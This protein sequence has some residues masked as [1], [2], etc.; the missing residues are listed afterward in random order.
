[1]KIARF[2]FDKLLIGD[3][4]FTEHHFNALVKYNDKNNG[5]FFKVGNKKIIF[6]N[7][8]GLLQVG[9]LT[10]EIL[11]KADKNTEDTTG[12]W[13]DALVKMLNICRYIRLKSISDANLRLRSA[14]LF[15]LYIESFL[16][17]FENIMHQGLQKKYRTIEENSHIFKG[18][19]KLSRHLKINLIHRERF[20]N[21]FDTYDYDNK[22]NQILCKALRILGTFHLSQELKTR[23]DRLIIN[24]PYISDKVF[25][26][27]DFKSLKQER[28][29]EKYI[30]ALKLA[31]LI[32]LY[33]SPDVST[34]TE[35]VLAILFDM[36]KLFEEFVY[37]VLK[38]YNDNLKVSAQQR[39]VFW[40]SETISKGIRPDMIIEKE[41][42]KMIVD[43]K[44]KVPQDSTPS[45][46]DLKQMYVYNK[47]FDSQEAVLLYPSTKAIMNM[48]GTYTLKE[49]GK[50]TMC[51]LRSFELGF[52]GNSLNYKLTYKNL[53]TALNIG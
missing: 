16:T 19:L 25:T 14:S 18:K 41:S 21:E 24:L 48:D 20:Y 29:T 22:Y 51:N 13:H 46:A 9:N 23:A 53:V 10:I 30:L 38:K 7:Y 17:E 8:V 11:P 28:S 26:E 12:K 5:K 44:W 40:E 37:R 27:Q 47:Y 33:Y 2:E 3:E 15:E 31:R 52:E 34:G 4:G 42:G 1:M 45:D 36:N 32:I 49:S 35:N 50:Q 43:T 6:N 39:M